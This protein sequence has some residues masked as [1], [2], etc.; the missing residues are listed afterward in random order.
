MKNCIEPPYYVVDYSQI[1]REAALAGPYDAWALARRDDVYRVRVELSC[2]LP[3][4][5]V[6]AGAHPPEF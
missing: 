2:L 1:S 4:S 6:L 5:K 3:M